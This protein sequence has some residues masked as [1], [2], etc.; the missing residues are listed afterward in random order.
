MNI[1]SRG[2]RAGSLVAAAL[3]VAAPVAA[4]AEP[5]KASV[6]APDLPAFDIES[7]AVES[8]DTID[9]SLIYRIEIELGS[10]LDVVP[11]GKLPG[12]VEYEIRT[13]SGYAL[14]GGSFDVEG[15][16]TVL[17]EGRIVVLSN[18]GG[19]KIGSQDEIIFK[20]SLGTKQVASCETFCDLCASKAAAL[21]INGTTEYA[22]SCGGESKSCSFRCYFPTKRAL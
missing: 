16:R 21:C 3:I 20:A 22:C 11:F 15:S 17:E 1:Y 4:A 9:G 7:V 6:F 8:L 10:T 18:L 19:I 5:L 14:G 2:L 13:E 12:F